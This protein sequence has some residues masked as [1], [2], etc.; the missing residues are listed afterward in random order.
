MNER[1]KT[2]LE[3]LEAAIL[4]GV[5][6]DL[7]LRV[8]YVGLNILLCVLGLSAALIML[9]KRR[10]PELWSKEKTM[11]HVALVF[12]AACFAW[13]DSEELL[14]ADFLAIMTI[15]AIMT[16][17]ALKVKTHLAGVS[18]YAIGWFWSG[19][20]VAFSPF[21]IVFD[22]IKWTKI[23][24]TGWTKHLIAVLRG[25]AIVAPILLIFTALFMAADAVFQGIIEKTFRI[26][27]DMLFSHLILIGFVSWITAGYLRGS[28]Y[29][30]FGGEN[31]VETPPVT[32]AEEI[33]AQ[34]LSVTET[35]EQ[36]NETPKETPKTEPE[37]TWTLGNFDNSILPNWATLGTIEI[38]IVLG[39]INLLFLSFVITQIP[40]LFGGFELVQQTEGLKLADYARRGFGE[41]VTVAALVLPIL[42]VSHWLL[43]KDNP[44]NEL[45][46]RVLAGI[47]IIL[48]FVIMASAAQRLFV[49]TGNLG[50]GLTTIRFY[51]L[52]FMMW[53]ALVFAWFGVSVLRGMRS[54]FAWGAFWLALFMLGGLHFFNPDDF[55]ARTNVRLMQEGRTFDGSYHKSLSADAYPVLMQAFPLMNEENKC[56]LIREVRW[57]LGR[58]ITDFRSWNYSRETAHEKMNETAAS[59]MDMNTCKTDY[60]SSFDMNH[61]G[62]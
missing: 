8:D 37:K 17:P 32:V 31:I 33:K 6:G 57:K 39:L 62:E 21:F 27:P 13:R 29:G 49:L 2:G 19:I 61:R 14:V 41:L 58:P 60:S 55:I 7:L 48:L 38:C 3:I 4:L 18:H 53:L 44:K 43:R 15:L 23:P 9:V 26:S 47:Q 36:P 56:H 40:Y 1:T 34:P 42:L 5:L 28:L 25:L 45:I 16:L 22:D 46:F 54:Q 20:N 10:K 12:F 24:Q 52:V 50:Y 51:P 30:G 35:S 59:L 11:L